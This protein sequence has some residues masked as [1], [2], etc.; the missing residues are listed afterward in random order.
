[1]TPTVAYAVPMAVDDGDPH[2]G[3]PE[4][5]PTA[6]QRRPSAAERSMPEPVPLRSEGTWE[7]W[8]AEERSAQAR[9]SSIDAGRRKAGVAGAAL[10]GSMLVLRDIYEGP[11]KDD[12]AIQ[13][14]ATG[15]THD[16][17]RD[18]ISMIVDG[19]QVSAPPL[20]E[21]PTR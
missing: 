3:H 8:L 19:V 21:R 16:I 1:M 6:H 12:I 7:R 5:A 4:L 10:A 11:P 15:E 13:I 2:L 9:L 18:G 17:D 20:G 14:E